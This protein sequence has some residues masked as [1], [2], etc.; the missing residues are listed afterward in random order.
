MSEPGPARIESEY[1]RRSLADLDWSGREIKGVDFESCVLRSCVLSKASLAR[2]RFLD[3]TFESCDLG[4]VKVPNTRLRGVKF[5]NCKLIG[6]NWSPL[7][8][9][10]SV[11]FEKC[12][13]NYSN[14]AGLDLRLTEFIGCSAR[15]ADFSDCDLSEAVFTGTDLL[16]ARFAGT[17]LGK[18]DFRG[19]TNYQIDP[20]ANKVR[21]AKFSLP[22]AVSLLRG[23]DIVIDDPARSE[24]R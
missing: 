7:S 6:V 5:K 8:A 23:L 1:V 3:C 2:C 21:K 16:G 13:L 19:A 11:S 24:V 4:L 14:F 17:N 20:T 22:E 18:S 15:E 10:V 9:A 12:Q